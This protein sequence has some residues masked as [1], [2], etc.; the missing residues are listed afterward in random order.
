MEICDS[1][2]CTGCALCSDIC[3]QRAITMTYE[4]GFYK[5]KID[6]SKCINCN[7][8]RKTC[9]SNNLFIA[10]KLRLTHDCFMAYS[11]DIPTHYECSSG[12]L[13]TEISRAFIQSGGIVVGAWYNPSTSRVE[14]RLCRTIEDIEHLRK[15]KYVQSYLHGIYSEI[16]K[17]IKTSKVLFIGVPCQVNAVKAYIGNEDRAQLYTID[18][19]CRGGAS[20]LCLNE[21]VNGASNGKKV[22]SISFRGGKYDCSF[23][24]YD[25]NSKVIFRG[26][27]YIDPY[28]S[29]FME[30][31]IF[32]ESCYDCKFAGRERVGDITVGDFWGL[33]EKCIPSVGGRG[34]NMVI[35]NNAEGKSLLSA[36]EDKVFFYERSIIEAIEGNETLREPTA[37]P[38]IY[39]SLWCSI[40]RYGFISGLDDYE[41]DYYTKRIKECKKWDRR[42]KVKS[43]LKYVLP[44]SVIQIIRRVI[45]KELK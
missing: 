16:K 33:E 2:I 22:N 30:H 39:D 32:N 13:C 8:C 25:K 34:V 15:S 44:N 29:C 18:L 19:L 11:S 35:V 42:Q 10:D 5:P 41:E 14:H 1:K 21:H 12:G 17:I 45:R 37:K 7:L 9:P 24:L 20:P 38:F 31:V 40:R 28:F 26:A 6:D 3:P 43:S 4:S 36:V 27:Q 23:V